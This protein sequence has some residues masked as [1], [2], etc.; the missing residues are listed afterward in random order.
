MANR[1]EW[2]RRVLYLARRSR[3]HSEL[4]DEMEFHVESR[5]EEVEQR[6]M[7]R[8]EALAAARRES[9]SAMRAAEGTDEAWRIGWLDDLI[10]DS[11]YAGRALRRNPGFALSAIACL[12]LGI[13]ANTTVFSIT[14]SFLF[15]VPSCADASSLI[16]IW[17]AATARRRSRII[18]S[19]GTR[20]Y[21]TARRGSTGERDQLARRR[22]E[23]AAVRGS[24]D[25]RL[26][27]RAGSAPAIGPRHCAR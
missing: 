7:P 5:A 23:R 14:T 1:I 16:A 9:G 3:F 26:F 15:S 11:R 12:A 27:Q 8:A 13:G 21:S 22:P 19:C 20:G 25:G 6:G 2:W 24:S 17:E 10:S 4:R 18:D